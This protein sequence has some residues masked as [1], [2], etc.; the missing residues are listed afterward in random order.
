MARR[1]GGKYSP[2]PQAPAGDTP[3]PRHPF[4]GKAP[5]RA[6]GRANV[7]FFVPLVL[8]P[9]AF[10][11]D[12][13]GLALAL[14]AFGALILA[15]WLTRE[16]LRAEDAWHARK[17]ARRPAIP[18]K[19]F[20]SVLTGLGLFLAGFSP[21]GSLLPPLIYA[22]LGAGLH[23]LSFGL[24]PLTDKGMEGVDT[25]QQDRVARVIDEAEK[26]LAAM[27]QAI[28]RAGDRALEARVDRFQG[29]VREMFRTVE[30]DPRDLTAARKYL[31]VYL[32]GA[33]DATIKFADFY[34]RT[35]DGAA[36]RDYQTLLDDLEAN[37]SARTRALLLDDRADLDVEIE[38]LRERLQR[39]GVRPDPAAP[40]TGE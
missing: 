8:L 35:R 31:V 9:R 38:V 26:H 33:R 40:I 17:I 32:L 12:P 20:G 11:S 7:A 18:R 23:S 29:T 34:G 37:F 27:Q 4:H 22:V 10:T 1:F 5:S 25:F 30:E 21:D 36:R 15:A 14:S 2:T 19:I 3:P 24:D 16:G 6:G 39:E 13:T 28:R